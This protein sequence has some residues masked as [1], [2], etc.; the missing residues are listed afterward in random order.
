MTH[1]VVYLIEKPNKI[2]KKFHFKHF[3][4]NFSLQN[5]DF[6]FK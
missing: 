4:I 1:S 3:K 6:F 2:T 5:F